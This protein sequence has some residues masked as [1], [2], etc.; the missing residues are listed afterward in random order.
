MFR[1]QGASIDR[2]TLQMIR[3]LLK[4]GTLSQRNIAYECRVSQ[5]TVARVAKELR[6]K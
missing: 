4:L 6:G 3:R 1:K 2:G 5:M